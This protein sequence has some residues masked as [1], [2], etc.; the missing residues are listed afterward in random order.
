MPRIAYDEIADAYA[1]I[2]AAALIDPTSVLGVATRCLLATVGPVTDLDVC[3]LGCGEGHLARS[4]AER[5]GRVVGVDLSA[6]LLTLARAR[7]PDST[8]VFVRDDAQ[9]LNALRDGAFDLV[10]ANLA[11]TDV[12]DLG[13]T[14]RAVR[15][16]LRPRG[17]FVFSITHPCFQAPGASIDL[18]GEGQF[19]GRRVGRYV[20]EGFWRS[21]N[22]EGI[23]GRVGAYHRTLATYLNGLVAVGFTIRGLVEP[24][25]PPDR[26]HD[27][28]V[29]GQARVPSVLVI[30]AGRPTGLD[31]DAAATIA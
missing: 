30:D 5:R 4:L 16:V 25:L 26:S 12:P 27:P 28:Y 3:D 19:A 7:T 20:A 11:L 9:R 8:V 22:E 18:D 23:R 31:A 15:R 1:A 14:Y 13:A 17:R 6:R 21:T 10:V 24:T 2:V 29:Q